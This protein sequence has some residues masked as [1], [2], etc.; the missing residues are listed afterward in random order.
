MD[1]QEIK[2]NLPDLSCTD[3]LVSN[4]HKES[5]LAQNRVV[6][7]RKTQFDPQQGQEWEQTMHNWRS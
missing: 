6:I 7:L 3:I 5:E 2:I 4:E 1:N